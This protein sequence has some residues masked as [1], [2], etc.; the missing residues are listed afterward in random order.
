MG[1]IKPPEIWEG[2][3][4]LYTLWRPVSPAEGRIEAARSGEDRGLVRLQRAHTNRSADIAGARQSIRRCWKLRVVGIDQ[5]M[6]FHHAC[7]CRIVNDPAA[8]M[9]VPARIPFQHPLVAEHAAAHE[10]HA[11][12]EMAHLRNEATVGSIQVGGRIVR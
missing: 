6:A 2:V 9:L 7:R 3:G 12:L 4:R 8:I 11:S 5:V 1:R 10:V